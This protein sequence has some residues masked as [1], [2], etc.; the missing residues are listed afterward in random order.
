MMPTPAQQLRIGLH[1]ADV[2]RASWYGG[3]GGSAPLC[4]QRL[5]SRVC[6]LGRRAW[7]R[8]HTYAAYIRPARKW[9]GC[10]SGSASWGS[11]LWAAHAGQN[12]AVSRKGGAAIWAGAP[13]GSSARFAECS[14]RY[15]F[16]MTAWAGHVG[17]K[18]LYRMSAYRKNRPPNPTGRSWPI[19]GLL[20]GVSKSPHGAHSIRHLSQCCISQILF[21]RCA[22]A[23][24]PK[25]HPAGI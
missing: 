24:L 18:R 9:V 23:T 1:T 2:T 14:L 15:V 3:L 6:S 16:V 25:R 17:S 4:V 21:G 22:A 19:S 7:R 10:A 8:W 13:K 11:P 12:R 20:R 5:G